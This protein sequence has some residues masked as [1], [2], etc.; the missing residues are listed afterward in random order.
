MTN[1]NKSK[2]YYWI[3]IKDTFM[4]SDKVDFLMSQK[5]GANYIVLY[6]MLCLMTINTDGELARNI[7]KILIPFDIDK[8]QR[9]CK[10]FSADTIR[11]ALELYKNLGMI[12][13]QENGVLKID[14]FENM[15]G[16]E[17]LGA[18]EKRESR[19]NQK[20]LGIDK[21]IDNVYQDNRYKILD[22]R[23]KNIDKVDNNIIDN[24]KEKKENACTPE[25]ISMLLRLIKSKLPE[26]ED[27]TY[28]SL[29][30]FLKTLS[31]TYSQKNIEVSLQHAL[32]EVIK[33]YESIDN[34]FGYL[35]NAIAIN[36]EQ[37][38]EGSYQYDN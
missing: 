4:T 7:G 15:V 3:K 11:V 24:N 19:E 30:V 10:Y 18:I 25:F 20:L 17:T 9:D 27:S 14:N 34:P 33:N 22:N 8:I 5:D 26:M 12:F 38:K 13:V 29:E 36:C 1:K 23:Y 2:R 28:I 37:F 21:E 6:Q 32:V 16:S 35:R 31:K